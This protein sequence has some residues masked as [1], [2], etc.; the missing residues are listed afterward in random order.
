MRAAESSKHAP[1]SESLRVLITGGI[2]SGKSVVARICRLKG[3]TVFDTDSAATDLIGPA[4][5]VGRAMTERWGSCVFTPQGEYNRRAVADI[6]FADADQRNW[7]NQLIHGKVRAMY[8]ELAASCG[9]IVFVEC[10]LPTTSH[11]ADDCDAV[12]LVEA[13]EATRL[14][15]LS[16]RNPELPEAQARQRIA[17]QLE[18]FAPLYGERVSIIRNDGDTPLL[19]TVD[20]LLRKISNRTNRP[21]PQSE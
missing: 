2:G 13:D 3:Y 9:G 5:E 15:R 18:E 11:I 8:R 7:L 4:T 16:V 10:A 21:A 14:A 17:S 6:I 1:V 12:W 20:S 19:A